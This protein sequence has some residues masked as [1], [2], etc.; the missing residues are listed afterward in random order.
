VTLSGYESFFLGAA[1][2]ATEEDRERE[3]ERGRERERER[4]RGRNQNS[5]IDSYQTRPDFAS[6]RV[7]QETSTL[8]KKDEMHGD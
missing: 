2:T 3:R 4:E 5:K 6:P 1:V 7:V 8:R